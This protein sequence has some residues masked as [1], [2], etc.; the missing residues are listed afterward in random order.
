[1]TICMA[2]N[3]AWTL[4]YVAAENM[5]VAEAGDDET[6]GFVDVSPDVG[7]AIV[8]AWFTSTLDELTSEAAQV[9]LGRLRLLGAVSSGAI[10]QTGGV[11]RIAAVCIGDRSAAIAR[12]FETQLGTAVPG[13]ATSTTTLEADLTVVFRTGGSYEDLIAVSE[14][15]TR[16][17]GPHLLVDA[18]F[19]HTLCIG[20][21]VTGDGTTACLACL[22]A[23][24]QGRWGASSCPPEPAASDNAEF[25]ATLTANEVRNWISRTSTL[26]GRVVRLDMRTWQTSFDVVLRSPNC[27]R[28]QQGRDRLR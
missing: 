3:P 18:S 13:S 15:L 24:L 25:V 14:P 5:L 11:L 22:A 20:P 7:E 4:R 23:R 1:V 21:V 28:C 12:A 19:H 26:V 8:S 17:G 10:T 2:A 6:Y 16:T 9:I 27:I